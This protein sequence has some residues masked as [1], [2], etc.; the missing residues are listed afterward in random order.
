MELQLQTFQGNCKVS[1]NAN[2]TSTT[3]LWNMHGGC[4]W[5]QVKDPLVYST[6]RY[7]TLRYATLRYA[8]LRYATLRYATLRYSTLLY[9]T[10]RSTLFFQANSTCF[11]V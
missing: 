9:S 6:L 5:C 4:I 1:T 11:K 10:L 7:A 8:T 2:Q 3:S